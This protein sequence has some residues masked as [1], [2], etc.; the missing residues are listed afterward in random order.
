MGEKASVLFR[1]DNERTIPQQFFPSCLRATIIENKQNR[2][3]NPTG[4]SLYQHPYFEK[5]KARYVSELLSL[6]QNEP[7]SIHKIHLK[8]NI[9]K[10]YYDEINIERITQGNESKFMKQILVLEMSIIKSIL[11]VLL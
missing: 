7:I 6:L 2:P 1:L 4:V 5:L 8:L 3:I 10:N 11:M 9:D